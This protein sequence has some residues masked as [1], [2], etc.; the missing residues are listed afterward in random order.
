M[1]SR[2]HHN[3]RGIALLLT[4]FVIAL[5]TILVMEL[6]STSKF[7][8]RT[9]RGF[10]EQVQ[11]DYILR[12]GLNLAKLLLEV[13][14]RPEFPEDWLGEPWALIGSAPTLPISGFVGT[15]QMAIVDEDGKI[16]VNAILGA[17]SFGG[18]PGADGQTQ[19]GS[20]LSAADYWKTG[21]RELFTR[22]GFTRQSYPAEE[23]R[24]PGNQSFD[25]AEQVA[26]IHDFIDADSVAHNSPSFSGVG[27][28][29]S[30]NAA[31][32]YNRPLK[33]MSELLLVPGITADRWARIGPLVRV[34]LPSLASSRR[35]N[36]NTA[37]LEVLIA[38]GFPE[39]QAAEIY[40]QRQNLPIT[41]Q[42]LT[43]LVQGDPQ[44]SKYTKVTS[45]EFSVFVRVQ[46][47]TMTRWLRAKMS[48]QGTGTRRRAQLSSIEYF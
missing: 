33:T 40:Q 11:S 17:A 23:F 13:P 21:L 6:V 34:G 43:T 31:L 4:V 12:S 7:D 32:F 24:T 48:V 39:N 1:L 10:A 28:E 46:M 27:I 35:I 20:Q 36:V 9:S 29:S 38:L 47:P 25:P 41:N 5:A 26:V 2:P 45:S 44:L 3:E 30:S 8:T 16:D 42:I 18:I 22:A 14:K 37:P 19:G 15:P